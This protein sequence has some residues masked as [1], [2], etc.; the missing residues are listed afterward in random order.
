MPISTITASSAAPRQSD[1]KRNEKNDSVRI[2]METAPLLNRLN[3]V[4]NSM[5]GL[6]TT[7]DL[8]DEELK[9][10]LEDGKRLYQAAQSRVHSGNNDS[11]MPAFKGGWLKK[12][13][14]Y[15][16][17]AGAATGGAFGI[18]MLAGYK[19]GRAAKGNT[20]APGNRPSPGSTAHPAIKVNQTERDTIHDD[21]P[22]RLSI[23]L[24]SYD[25]TEYA[26]LRRH[27]SDENATGGPAVPRQ[28][29]SSRKKFH[30]ARMALPAAT[31]RANREVTKLLREH[32][33]LDRGKVSKESMLSEVAGCLYGGETG[34]AGNRDRVRELARKMLAANRLYGGQ[35]DEELSFARA[36]AVVGQWLFRN[37]LGKSPTE[38]I[39]D[40]MKA[41]SY[42]EYYTVSSIR[43]LLDI[44]TL[45]KGR[46]IHYTRIPEEQ[47][48]NFNA[49]WHSA[50]KADMPFL[51]FAEDGVPYNNEVSVGRL[52]LG[53]CEFANLFTGSLF[54]KNLS[55]EEF[56]SEEAM[57]VGES[58]W[59]LAVR[60][61]VT[62][63]KIVY[64][65]P[66]ALFFT[67]SESSGNGKQAGDNVA[68]AVNSYVRFRETF[69]EL[70]QDIKKKYDDYLSAM[71][72]WNSK[73]K[74]ADK[75]V[76]EC[77]VL[78][79]FVPVKGFVAALNREQ[80]RK[81]EEEEAKEFYM[82]GMAKP[83]PTAP[84]SLVD[85]Y[86]ALTTDVSE[87]FKD[88]DRYLVLSALSSLH[89][90]E[91]IFISSAN[92]TLHRILFEMKTDRKSK[93][94][95]PLNI[96]TRISLNNTDLF[97]AR[98]G[99]IERIYALKKNDKSDG[100]YE[101]YRVD[102]NIQRYTYH[103][104]LDRDDLIIA[105]FMNGNIVN[106]TPNSREKIT[107]KIEVADQITAGGNTTQLIDHLSGVHRNTF[108]NSL[109]ESGNSLTELEEIWHTIKHFIPFYDC[110]D[111]IIRQ[112]AAQA[113]PSC[114]LD[115]ISFLPVAGEAV[116]LSSRF[117]ISI[118]RQ[119]F[120][121]GSNSAVAVGRSVLRGASLPTSKELASLGK[122]VLKAADPGFQLLAAAR[123]GSDFA[124][125]VAALLSGS[126][127][128][129][130]LAQKMASE[131][132]LARIPQVT[133]GE[134]IKGKLPGTDLAVPVKAVDRLDDGRDV[135]VRVNPET[136][137]LFGKR[138]LINSAGELGTVPAKYFHIT[139]KIK[140]YI[141]PEIFENNIDVSKLSKPDY[142]GI[143]HDVN[144]N[145]Y[146]SVKG[147][148][149]KLKGGID[150]GEIVYDKKKNCFRV[151]RG[152]V[153]GK[154][155]SDNVSPEEEIIEFI[156]NEPPD[157]FME[158]RV[159]DEC[160]K[161]LQHWESSETPLNESK[162][163]LKKL[164][165]LASNMVEDKP[166]LDDY[167]E[168][169][170][171]GVNNYLRY[172]QDTSSGEYAREAV[173]LGEAY[174][175]L[176]SYDDFS[177]RIIVMPHERV[178]S[179]GVGDIVADKGFSSS[180]AL[181]NNAKDWINSN[182]IKEYANIGDD[183]ILIVYDK[184]I[185][186]KIAGNHF[187]IDHILIHPS[188]KI[189]IIT[190]DTI[191]TQGKSVT[192]IGAVKYEGNMP[193]SDIYTGQ[194]HN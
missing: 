167:I 10:N 50:L 154:M 20:G 27:L 165:Y 106:L 160:K 141:T 61:G 120:R 111:G 157:I 177:Y 124:K 178:E 48:G 75:I 83:C 38:Y 169:G 68:A 148:Y 105:N 95:I 82:L 59:E 37:V 150:E 192:I 15:T 86:N 123:P 58:M 173:E 136:A 28:M 158:K 125:K 33:L 155:C 175:E 40:R 22:L 107:C 138:Y 104:L 159:G 103:G 146:I 87:K 191:N 41:D 9:D 140:K 188:E 1:V 110:I 36:E 26:H 52:E 55:D 162:D 179:L 19:S 30:K 77:P 56:T 129:P 32:G 17:L 13:A 35:N 144:G 2:N 100:S 142:T 11:V 139:K 8:Q 65:G 74:L 166:V 170:N 93:G 174:N 14:I 132:W 151:P 43:H 53:S 71:K 102:R 3:F 54:L 172:G 34:L 156:P 64:Y 128:M 25:D 89:E 121:A 21:R 96:K 181:I 119:G 149:L 51:K 62:E 184:D 126:K 186:K 6:N 57:A 133:S 47:W 29:R 194:L 189:K 67:A 78:H 143:Q 31:K 24:P 180:S 193:S 116:S 163:N 127:K 101:I 88:I 134:L 176:N 79:P 4:S 7:D 117:G 45:L 145:K 108:Y 42:P 135:Y 97:A 84:D 5:S 39:T 113:L 130:G 112:D 190:K 94:R 185:P 81:R 70:Q 76:A 122:S 168:S 147:K 12:C 91:R 115:I 18:G 90:D 69:T 92:T 66:P 98:R 152:A 153:L 137:E 49:M 63:D 16:L 187:L 23:P 114:F 182:Y 183:F 99:E 161:I 73:S 118:A 46:L 80:L 60:E 109:Y 44:E 131:G 85:T 164:S 72:K 171:D